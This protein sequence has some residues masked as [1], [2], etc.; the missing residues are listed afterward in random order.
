MAVSGKDS[1]LLGNMAK[2]VTRSQPHLREKRAVGDLPVLAY[3]NVKK[4]ESRN[5]PL[6]TLVLL[7]VSTKTDTLS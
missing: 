3:S 6:N 7:G 4:E 1:T 5:P 2:E